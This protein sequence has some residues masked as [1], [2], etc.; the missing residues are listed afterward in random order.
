MHIHPLKSRADLDAALARID[1]LWGAPAGS[2]EGDELDVLL[3][4]VEAYESK[5]HNIPVGDP[6]DVVRFKMD[7]LG[8]SQNAL[9]Q[10]VGWTSGRVSEVLNRKRDLTLAMVRSL[11]A[12]LSISPALLV[13]GA[14]PATEGD[15]GSVIS[16]DLP[17][18]V[19]A[20]VRAVPEFRNQSLESSITTLVLR[21]LGKASAT[22]SSASERKDDASK[23][24]CLR[25]QG[26]PSRHSRMAA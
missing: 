21:G 12:A 7:E 9:A 4:L 19:I 14:A 25:P 5:N 11:A 22:A 8:L 3:T 2:P 15:S 23:I 20:K 1:A 16:V 26:P 10:K 6:I 13:G 24:I 17:P 18:G